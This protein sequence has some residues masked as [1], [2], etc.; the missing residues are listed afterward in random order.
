[1]ASN[2]VKHTH[3]VVF[4]RKEPGCVRCGQLMAGAP[5]RQGWGRRSYSVTDPVR[6]VRDHFDGQRHKSGG[7]GPVCTFGDS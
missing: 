2:I 5:A 3:P 6:E 4:G 1:M 7:C